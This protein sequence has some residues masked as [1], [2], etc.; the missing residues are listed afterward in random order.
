MLHNHLHFF[1]IYKALLRYGLHH[2]F[3]TH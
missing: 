2:E 3:M 1:R